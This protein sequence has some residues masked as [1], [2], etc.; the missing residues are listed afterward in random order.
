[1]FHGPQPIRPIAPMAFTVVLTQMEVAMFELPNTS[2][3]WTQIG[4]ASP[5]PAEGG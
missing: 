4:V 3:K 5:T 1:M 2:F